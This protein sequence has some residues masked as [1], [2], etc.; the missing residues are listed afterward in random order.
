MTLL[1]KI[2][3]LIL[4]Y[5]EIP[6]IGRTIER[7]RWADKIVVIDSFSS[8]GT[9]E[10]CKGN[11]SIKAVQRV[12]DTAANQNNFGLAHVESEWVLS[13]DADYVLSDELIYELGTLPDEPLHDGYFIPLRYCVFGKQLRSSILPPRCSLYRRSK[14]RYF[15]D[16]HTQRVKVG[17]NLGALRHPILHDDRKSLS[18]W[19][20]SQSRYSEREA[21]K[22]LNTP[23]KLL[24][25]TD[26]L[27]KL[28]FIAPPLMLLY[29][30]VIK[31]GI[32]D[33]WHG[34]YYAFQRTLAELLLALRLIERENL[35]MDARY[36]DARGTPSI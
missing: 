21:A 19:L 8:D 24:R 14:A 5:N 1:K 33:G 12:F 15:D 4:A 10:F 28:K 27:R 29:T 22:L 35:G 26:R 9:W 16:G 3:P 30:L 6:N 17:G 11:S 25:F 2:T 13:M 23:W 7:L 32:L 31:G 34:C 20:E 36:G 18:R